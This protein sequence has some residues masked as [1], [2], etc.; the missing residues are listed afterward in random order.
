MPDIMSAEEIL[1][2]LKARKR[3]YDYPRAGE[4]MFWEGLSEEIRQDL[5]ANGEAAQAQSVAFLSVKDYMKFFRDGNRIDY[6]TPYFRR[7]HALTALVLAECAE[8]KGRFMDD[9]AEYLWQILSEPVWCLPA[10]QRLTDHSLPGPGEW[11]VDLFAAE[12]ARILSE[13]LQLLRPE[14]EKEFLPLVRRIE[15]EV[16]QRVLEVCEKTIFWWYEGSNNWSVWCCYSVNTAAIEIWQNDLE[17]LA[18]FLSKH[19]VPMKNFYDRYAPDGGCNEGP[20]YWLVAVGM[21]MNGLEALQHR[22]GGFEEWFADR[23]IKNMVEFIPRMNFCGKWFMGFSD[24]E[25][26]FPRFPKGTFLKYAAMVGSLPMAQ[27]ALEIP[28]EKSGTGEKDFRSIFAD[29][30]ADLSPRG[31]FKRN[32]VDFWEDLKIWI[33]RQKPEDAANGMVCSLKAG[34]NRQSHNHM[35]LGHFSLWQ[36]NAPVI[37]DV[38]RGVYSR[39]CFSGERYTLWNLNSAG[40]NGARFDGGEQGFG[41]E[42]CADLVPQE[43]GVICDLTAA[44]KEENGIKKYCRRVET[45]WEQNRV[46]LDETAE[47]DGK[48]RIEINFYTPVEPEKT[49]S[50]LRLKDVDLC[51]EGI[52]ITRIVK[53]DWA[54]DKINSTWGGLWEICLSTEAEKSAQWKIFFTGVKRREK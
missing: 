26:F 7:R 19:I 18:A 53:V 31:A 5:I 50:G 8:Y 39:A 34:H 2:R 54:D 36:N 47:F 20:S 1:R 49:A 16:T 48:K 38:G 12:T 21:L 51:C 52:E 40:H 25:S 37:I 30:T 28:V 24:A 6:E 44:F 32:A 29:L 15:F 43:R 35:D 46:L 14:L 17:R 11:V 13:V 45:Q 9:I 22:L 4:R 3:E 27:L 41:I 42:Y 33:A 23:K 10:H